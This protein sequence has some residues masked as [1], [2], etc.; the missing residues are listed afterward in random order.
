MS[1]SD[2]FL[3]RWSRRKQQAAKAATLPRENALDGQTAEKVAFPA[4]ASR[5]GV[6]TNERQIE[7]AFDLSKL[8]S[9]DSIGPETNIRLF[10]Q[11]GVP[12]SLSR[13]ALRRA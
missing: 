9:L 1:S 10:M 11:P 13:A 7:P 8:P 2:D 4:E 12:A 6:A 5:A 3:S